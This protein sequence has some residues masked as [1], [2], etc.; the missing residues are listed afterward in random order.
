[1]HRNEAPDWRSETERPKSGIVPHSP[2]AD[3]SP[4][5]DEASYRAFFDGAVEGIFRTTRS[6]NYLAA[7][8]ALARMYGYESP[9]QLIAELTDIAECL[10]VD[11]TRRDDFQALLKAHDQVTDFESEIRRRDGST[12]WIAENARAVRDQA[13]ALL[14][15]EGTVE[16]VTARRTAET[17]LR[18]ALKAA[19]AASH[20]KSAFLATMSHELKTPLNAVIGF[21][22]I[23]QNE[24]F[25][26]LG[27][28][29]YKSFATHIAESGLHLLHVISAILDLSRLECGEIQIEE[30]IICLDELLDDLVTSATS[31]H[32]LPLG[33]GAAPIAI[34]V[35]PGA[36]A[37]RA[38]ARRV[39]Q[40]LRNLLSNAIKF[41]SAEGLITISAAALDDGACAIRVADTGIGMDP[42]K[43]SLAL[44]PFKQIDGRLARRFDGLGLGLPIARALTAMHGGSLSI[45]SA[46]GY[47][48]TVSVVFPASRVIMP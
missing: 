47:G 18:E 11:P 48:T 2:Q 38:D 19:E 30:D 3:A 17:Q 37:L 32:A 23:L 26:A 45:Q 13:G 42:E 15:Y 36:P 25:G 46:L 4:H 8:P 31:G 22:Q 21:A 20:A 35:P 34:D 6:G 7:N 12:I 5:L 29:Q 28:P 16:D 43:I 39:R 41:T 33:A 27:H 9:A 24:S 10:Y 40:I 14:Y 1:M 44:E